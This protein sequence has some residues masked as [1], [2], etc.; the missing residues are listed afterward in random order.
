M[1]PEILRLPITENANSAGDS[2]H[3]TF[4]HFF[5]I[6]DR[7]LSRFA[8]KQVGNEI[9]ANLVTTVFIMLHITVECFKYQ[10]IFGRA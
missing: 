10:R 6:E 1:N 4:Y 3:Q 8:V 2:F 9:E 5:I 7:S